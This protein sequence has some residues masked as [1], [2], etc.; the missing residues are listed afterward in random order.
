[1]TLQEL[2]QELLEKTSKYETRR[3]SLHTAANLHRLASGN[4]DDFVI[5]DN[6]GGMA[7]AIWSGDSAGCLANGGIERVHLYGY[8][9][10]GKDTI[11]QTPIFDERT[12]WIYWEQKD[13]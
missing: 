13:D 11:V 5:F 1:M 3:I 6:A 2:A 10:A 7:F 12:Q 9:I 4:D 8:R